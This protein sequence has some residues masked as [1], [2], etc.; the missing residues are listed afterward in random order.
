MT[1]NRS[2]VFTLLVLASTI[3]AAEVLIRALEVPA[4]MVPPP[5]KVA[6][7]LWKGLSTGVYQRHLVV[8]LSET[9]IGFAIGAVAGLTI[10]T[11]VALNRYVDTL[12]YPYIVA[13]Q[14]LPKVALAPL[15]AVWFG[16]GMTSKIVN[17]A[18][19]AF[20]PLLVNV[21]AGLRSTDEDR[22]SLMRS[23][24]A[25]ERQIFWHVRLPGALPFVLAGVDVGIVFSLIGA[26]VG[27]FVGANEGL[28]YLMQSYNFSLDVSG[29]FSILIVL[30]V[31][32]LAL[33]RAV[34]EVR[35]RVLFWDPSEKDFGDHQVAA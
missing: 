15:I 31:V 10:G 3:L 12:A 16:L 1:R 33:H 21:I 29:S 9:L 18:L 4:F 19:I 24:A 32:G 26:I 7:A 6:A 35:K 11:M 27:E 8:T 2:I 14:S 25:T 5:S 30:A 20:F 17:A 23:L 13:F 28:G 34:V 22:I